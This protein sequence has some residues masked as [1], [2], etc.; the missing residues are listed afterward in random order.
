MSHAF[1]SGLV[2]AGCLAMLAGC[3]AAPATPAGVPAAA[4]PATVSAAATP[5]A[6]TRSRARETSAATPAATTATT[7]AAAPAS[8][9][10]PMTPDLAATVK[11]AR[12][13]GYYPRN[14]NGTI[15]YCKTEPQIGTRL[16]STSCISEADVT[17]IVQRSIDNRNDVEAL[18]RKSLN[19][20]QNN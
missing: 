9:A 2:A 15:V 11:S 18:Q 5:P 16:N 19:S 20:P 7:A 10:V 1:L 4:T 8:K 12:A 17:L 14:H 3:A 6:A 13:F